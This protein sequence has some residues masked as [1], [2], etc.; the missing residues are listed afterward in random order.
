MIVGA[1]FIAPG[2]TACGVVFGMWL[3][4]RLD[5]RKQDAEDRAAER[6]AKEREAAAEALR[7]KEAHE[8]DM[9]RMRLEA[10][11][12]QIDDK[13]QA[14][15]ERQVAMDQQLQTN[16]YKLEDIQRMAQNSRPAELGGGK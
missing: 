6:A 13:Q 10:Q 14:I 15:A 5:M 11:L 8:R 1:D 3:K 16:T 2:I 12:R 7:K 9:A 4:H